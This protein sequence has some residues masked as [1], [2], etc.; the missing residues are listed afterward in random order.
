MIRQIIVPTKNTFLLHLPDDLVGKEVEVI[1][2]STNDVT[3]DN[4][5]VAT[6]AT[7]TLKDAAAFYKKHSVDFTKIEKWSREDLYE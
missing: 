6:T 4:E 1:A 5:S 7:R 3:P 2:F